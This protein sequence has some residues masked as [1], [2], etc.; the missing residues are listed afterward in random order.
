MEAKIMQWIQDLENFRTRS[1]ARKSLIEAGSEV[2]P[3]LLDYIANDESNVNGVWAAISVLAEFKYEPAIPLLKDLLNKRESLA[4]DIKEAIFKISGEE[5][6]LVLDREIPIEGLREIIN[7]IPQE[8]VLAFELKQ[9]FT[10][11]V[12]KTNGERKH[13]LILV[14]RENLIEVYTECGVFDPEDRAQLEELNQSLELGYLDICEKEEGRHVL[15]LHYQFS[16]TTSAQEKALRR[17]VQVADALE[18]QLTGK[19][20][21]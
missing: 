20:E 9:G 13:E 10:S 21:I 5:I 7:R 3:I 12:L 18:D 17:L 2:G 1:K 19:D 16:L 15:T 6:S 8:E 4:W 14:Q 11:V